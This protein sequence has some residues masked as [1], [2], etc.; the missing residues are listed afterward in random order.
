[1]GRLRR[2]RK[3]IAEGDE[4]R[5]DGERTSIGTFCEAAVEGL[6]SWLGDGARFIDAA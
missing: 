4:G 3:G 1:M 2:G 6:M 5:D